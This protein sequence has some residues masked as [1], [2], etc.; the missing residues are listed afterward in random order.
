MERV[1]EAGFDGG[2]IVLEERVTSTSHSEGH[3]HAVCLAAFEFRR[4]E[5][6]NPC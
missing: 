3:G 5:V 6:S 4:Q 1:T 2:Q